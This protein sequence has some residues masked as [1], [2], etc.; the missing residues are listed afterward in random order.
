MALD[1]IAFIILLSNVMELGY[2]RIT[3]H[4][5]FLDILTLLFYAF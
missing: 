2:M 5:Q 4:L 1:L 3:L